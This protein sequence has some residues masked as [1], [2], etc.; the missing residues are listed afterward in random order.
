M[1]HKYN[2]TKHANH[3]K[4]NLDVTGI[5]LHACAQHGCFAPSSG[6]D[7]HKGERQM[8]VDYSLSQ[9]LAH[10]NMEG[11]PSVLLIYYLMCQYKVHLQQWF[12]DSE[13]LKFP[14]SMKTFLGAIGQFH[15]HTHQESCLYR[16]S[17]SF[18]PGAARVDG[19][20]LETLWSVLNQISPSARSASMGHRAEILDDHMAD[21][22]WKK[23][24]FMGMFWHTFSRCTTNWE[25]R[26]LLHKN[27]YEL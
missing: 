4:A 8:N 27:M 18:I 15:M 23:I 7:L 11:I 5:V 21:S 3:W 16:Y 1:C 2:V 25:Q 26:T 22:N 17:T 10:T 19:E 24:I 12:R 20:I 6:V 9:A 14:D 13:Y